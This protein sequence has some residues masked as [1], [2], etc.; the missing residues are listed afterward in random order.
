M[1]VAEM[2]KYP[3]LH[4]CNSLSDQASK[5]FMQQLAL[6]RLILILG[7]SHENNFFIFYVLAPKPHIGGRFV[8]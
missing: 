8:Q 4:C 7:W 6:V 5:I 3:K 1:Y 2:N